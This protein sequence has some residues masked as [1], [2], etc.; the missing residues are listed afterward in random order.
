MTTVCVFVNVVIANVLPNA[1]PNAFED[2]C[3]PDEPH[4]VDMK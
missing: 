2:G 4:I 3:T 1:A